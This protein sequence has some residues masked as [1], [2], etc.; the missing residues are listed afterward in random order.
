MQ[1]VFF[2]HVLREIAL[3]TAIVAAVLLV[4]LV[5][6]Q[7]S[8]VLGRAADGQ[9]PGELVLKIAALSLRSNIVIILPFALLLGTILGLGRLYHDSE[10]TA[11]QACGLGLVPL[12]GAAAV[13]TGIAV[14]IVAWIALL[15]APNAARDVVQMRSEALRTAVTRGLVP[16]QFKSLGVGAS[17]HFRAQDAD[18]SLRDV[19]IQR[20]VAGGGKMEIV[21]AD[22]A[23]YSLAADNNAYLI[24]LFDGASYEGVPGRGD[25]RIMNFE[26]QTVRV[27]TPEA[28]LPGKPRVDVI[29]TAQLGRATDSRQQAELHW[30]IG[31]VVLTLLAGLLAVPLAKLRPRQGRYA[32]VL[33]G[34]LL[35]AV[36]AG[37][38]SVAR[39]AFERGALP[40]GIG[41]WWVHGAALLLGWLLVK[42]AALRH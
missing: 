28:A 29:P 13:T 2:R 1:G 39:S 10:I 17:L 34:V 12:Y 30:R 21:V 5:T 41:L 16:G 26:Q 33:R 42:G 22:R 3:A 40:Q 11:A 24:Q 15:D 32:N 8:F 25:W 35:F 14:A 37:L 31:W 19:F 27:P 9:V 6:Y 38:L 7:L 4:I 36:Y 20:D 18:G 23:R